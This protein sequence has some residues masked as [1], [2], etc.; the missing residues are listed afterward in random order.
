MI[1]ALRPGFPHLRYVDD[2]C[3]FG[4]DK[5]RLAELRAAIVERLFRLRLRLNEGKSR[6]RQVKEGVEFLG[7]VVSSEQLRLNQTA[8]RRQ[9]R[10][11][12]RLQRDYAA[13]L[14][15]WREVAA[16]L[17]AWNAHAEYGTTWKLRRGVF[18][19]TPFIRSR[20]G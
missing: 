13:G 3:C 9:R 12:K 15:S 16:S 20:G 6:V 4:E 19:Q 2:F 10:R 17:H 18:E 5:H 1:R 7:F 14:L 8:V 11:L